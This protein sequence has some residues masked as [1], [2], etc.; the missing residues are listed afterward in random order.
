METLLKLHL[1]EAYFINNAF[2]KFSLTKKA[3][4][5][6]HTESAAKLKP[7]SMHVVSDKMYF[8]TVTF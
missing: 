8:N 5:Y 4:R 1:A 6:G 3:F 2:L 7:M